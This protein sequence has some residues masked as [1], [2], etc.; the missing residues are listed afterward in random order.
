MGFIQKRELKFRDF[1]FETKKVRYFNLDK[2]DKEE[3]DS[4]GN[5]T[6]FTGLKD[7]NGID[8]YEGDIM[9]DEFGVRCKIVYVNEYGRY[10]QLSIQGY[11]PLN[12]SAILTDKDTIIGNIYENPELL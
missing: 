2:Y 9:E 11:T 6:E 3:H 12:Q 4:Y 10:N 7:K 8:I 5:I 1:D